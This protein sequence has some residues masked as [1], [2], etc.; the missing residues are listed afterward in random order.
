MGVRKYLQIIIAQAKGVSD[1]KTR[2]VPSVERFPRSWQRRDLAMTSSFYNNS[3]LFSTGIT[4]ANDGKISHNGR[5]SLARPRLQ[6]ARRAGAMSNS[7]TDHI[8]AATL[9][10][11]TDTRYACLLSYAVISA[12]SG[13]W[14][15]HESASGIAWRSPATAGA[16]GC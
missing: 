15:N 8:Q 13:N 14:T 12:Q 7:E 11:L 3:T 9:H 1:L 16:C 6:G 2:P 10:N 5:G 4:I